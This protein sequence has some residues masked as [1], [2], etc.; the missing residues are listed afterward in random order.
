MLLTT[1]MIKAFMLG[2]GQDVEN[3]ELYEATMHGAPPPAYV[4]SY[5]SVSYLHGLWSP[6]DYGSGVEYAA[7][8]LEDVEGSSLQLGLYLD[9]LEAIHDGRCDLNITVLRGYLE[10]LAPRQA[11]VRIGY[12]F[13]NPMNK[14]EP[15]AYVQA[16]RVVAAALKGAPNVHTVWHSWS[17]EVSEMGDSIEDW[18]P[19]SD[20][21]DWCGVSI[22]QQ[23]FLDS[24]LGDL[25]FAEAMA[26]FCREQNLPLM[27]AES[28]PFGLGDTEP[29]ETIWDRWFKNVRKF[30]RHYDVQ[31]WCYI[32]VDWDLQRMWRGEGWGNTRIQDYPDLQERWIRMLRRQQLQNSPFRGIFHRNSGET[33]RRLTVLFAVPFVIAGVLACVVFVS[34]SSEHRVL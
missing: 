34:R 26:D 2:I 24:P 32:N 5:S 3:I 10:S 23:G 13:D 28:T 22:F 16:F 33:D 6:T 1:P 12:E 20:F 18:W 7:R 30:I 29:A 17:F 15:K 31:L 14:Y 11:L 27:I 8:S 21:V 4:M 19:G 9:D 25:S